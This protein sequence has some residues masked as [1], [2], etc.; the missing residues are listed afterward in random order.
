MKKYLAGAL[1]AL[2]FYSCSE[3]KVA[4][5]VTL[6]EL[7]ANFQNP[8]Q[9]ARPQVWWHWMNGNI[10]KDG[11][12]KDLTWMKRIGLGGFHHFDA[13]TAITPQIVENRLIYM[14]EG[15]KDAFNY[16]IGL[17]DSLGL[18]MTIA[19]APGWSSTGGPW[20]EPKDAMKK[21]VWRECYASG[22]DIQIT[23]PEP[24]NTTGTYQ[25]IPTSSS[26]LQDAD[27]NVDKYYEDVAVVAVK[28]PAGDLTLQ[29]MGAKVTTS[30]T[31]FTVDELTDGN[32]AQQNM[33]M[34]DPSGSAWI[35]YEFPE[36]QV[37]KSATVCSA[38]RGM[39]LQYSKDG[40]E[41]NDICAVTPSF[42]TATTL[43]F[44]MVKAKYYRLSIEN[45][46]PTPGFYGMTPDIPAAPGTVVSEFVLYP[47]TRV[48]LAVDKAGFT[49]GFN[50]LNKPTPLADKETFARTW[51][52]YNVTNDV[53]DGKLSW[54][55]PKDGKWRIFRFGFSLTGKKNHPAPAEATGLEV[56]KLDPIAWTNYFRKYLDMYKEA[57]HGMIGEKGIRYLLT[58]S[59]EAELMTWTPAMMDEFYKR[60]EYDLYKYLPALTGMIIDTPEKTD[61]FLKD[62]RETIGELMK[63]NYD[64]ISDIVKNE[65]GM[66]GRYTESHENERSFIGD[67]MDL[68][69]T[70]E[71][72]MSA[73][74][75]NAAWLAQKGPE[76]MDFDHTRYEMDDKESS[77]VA[78]IFGQNIAAAE[79][80]TAMGMGGYAYGF[81]PGNLKQVLDMEL[82]AGINRI[83]VHESAHQPLDTHKPGLSLMSTGQWFNRHETWAEQAKAWVDYMSRSCYMLQQGQNVA[84]VLVYYGEDTNITKLY[85][86][87]KP[88]V[89]AGYQYDFCSP[90]TFMTAIAWLDDQFIS[91]DSGTRYQVLWLDRNVDY[92]SNTILRKLSNMA[93]AGAIIA[94]GKPKH[95]AGGADDVA[96]FEQLVKSIWESGMENVTSGVELKDVLQKL[97]IKPDVK[98]TSDIRYLHRNCGDL[99]IY[100]VNKPSREAELV[101]AT[102]RVAGLKPQIWHP[103]TGAME[104]AT[105]TM[106]GEE[107]TVEIPMVSDDAVFVVFGEKTTETQF[108]VPAVEEK[109]VSFTTGSWTLKFQEGRGAPESITLNELMDLSKNQNN[110]VKYFSG[111]VNY[112]TTLNIERINGNKIILDLGE[113]GVMAHVT[114]NGKEAGY[115]WKQPYRIDVTGLLREGTNELDIE[116]ANL[117]KN[118]LIGDKQPGVTPVTFVDMPYYFGMEPL[119]ASGLMGPIH[120]IVK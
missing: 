48:H 3:P 99:Q 22:K 39:K 61:G 19:S 11:I 27:P 32:L 100:W 18:E 40:T 8:P 45:P 24:F 58:D 36:E 109:E 112:S 37:I 88:N 118:R 97:G 9:E 63:E 47:I 2:F 111:I 38:G 60:H 96:E 120:I 87:E 106:T 52:V 53:K 29:E 92:M 49:F 104:D 4:P 33:L 64:R 84:D 17:A 74:W 5:Q 42:V 28:L 66:K 94:G 78:H 46:L 34:A 101:K 105:Y 23:L 62:W 30:N 25:N 115:A 113:V 14:D 82:A 95:P 13:G 41:W 50:V 73:M 103:E 1:A 12:Y 71:I 59:Y 75:M 54:K 83:V 110:G 20:V 86:T 7:K 85:E 70:A 57:S 15:W 35:Q 81:W 21:L 79:S 102:F 107:T 108:T 80:M 56:D 116:V 119:S 65:Y 89:P 72:P 117:W 44:P 26:V 68:K 77:S 10:T 93:K 16:A 114:L 67:G 76:I 6:N 98:T 90:K 51:D 55:A 31:P 69:A 91:G 43:D